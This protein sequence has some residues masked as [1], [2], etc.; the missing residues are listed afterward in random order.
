M[1]VTDQH[2]YRYRC[3]QCN[4]TVDAGEHTRS[5]APDTVTWFVLTAYIPTRRDTQRRDFCSISCLNA[6][7]GRQPA[8]E[9]EQ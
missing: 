9:L 7:T 6:W 4:K 3:D 5:Q 2:V 1:S 8:K